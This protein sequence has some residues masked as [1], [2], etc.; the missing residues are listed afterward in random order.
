MTIGVNG[1]EHE[2]Y[3]D[4]VTYEQIAELA[5]KPGATHLTMTYHGEAVIDGERYEKNGSLITGESVKPVEGMH[6]CA[7]YTGNA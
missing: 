1:V 7:V 5:G 3:A 2:I 6:F 4:S